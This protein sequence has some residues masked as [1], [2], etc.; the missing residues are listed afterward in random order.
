MMPLDL[1][2]QKSDIDRFIPHLPAAGVGRARAAELR[3]RHGRALKGA[4]RELRLD[5]AKVA[6]DDQGFGLRLGWMG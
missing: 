5:G 6:F 1:P 2:A 4:L 3:V